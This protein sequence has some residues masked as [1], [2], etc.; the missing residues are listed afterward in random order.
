MLAK[1]V[2]IPLKKRGILKYLTKN[3]P[4]FHVK[5]LVCLKVAIPNG[6]SDEFRGFHGGSS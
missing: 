6:S 4:I 1:S 2:T 5:E 3:S